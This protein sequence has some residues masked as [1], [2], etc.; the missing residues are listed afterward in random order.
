L[1]YLRF[2]RKKAKLAKMHPDFCYVDKNGKMEEWKVGKVESCKLQKRTR[3]AP[4]EEYWKIE[5][6]GTECINEEMSQ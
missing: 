6:M 2:L 3:G 4:L 1:W 5:V